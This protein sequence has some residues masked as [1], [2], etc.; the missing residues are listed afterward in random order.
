MLISIPVP[1]F[2]GMDS[3]KVCKNTLKY[4]K[5]PE[6]GEIEKNLEALVLKKTGSRNLEVHGRR[7]IGGR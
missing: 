2:T 4:N 7:T 1:V 6:L 3:G 5:V